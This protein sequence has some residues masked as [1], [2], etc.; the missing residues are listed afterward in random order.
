MLIT[1]ADKYI[2]HTT[3]RHFYEQDCNVLLN[4][5]I[6]DITY[7]YSKQRERNPSYEQIIF[8]LFTDS[9]NIWIVLRVKGVQNAELCIVMILHISVCGLEES[10]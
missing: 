7:E 3:E 5:N 6:N 8:S 1:T 9:Y 4:D 2:L 10:D